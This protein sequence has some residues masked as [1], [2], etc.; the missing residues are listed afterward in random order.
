MGSLPPRWEMGAAV[1][2][3]TIR[4]DDDEASTF[5]ELCATNGV[6]IQACLLSAI[7]LVNE[8]YEAQGRIPTDEWSD[9]AMLIPKGQLIRGARK[10]DADHRS[11]SKRQ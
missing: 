8:V 6:S 1:T 9:T 11:R 2:K 5:S 10:I 3:W 4:L 7:R